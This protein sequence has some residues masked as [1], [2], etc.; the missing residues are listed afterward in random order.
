[1]EVLACLGVSAK[2]FKDGSSKVIWGLICAL[3]MW[4]PVPPGTATT[5]PRFPLPDK[6]W[7]TFRGI[8]SRPNYAGDNGI[9]MGKPGGGCQVE[10]VPFPSVQGNPRQYPGGSFV[11]NTLQCGGLQ[12]DLLL[13]IADG[14][15]WSSHWIWTGTCSGPDTGGFLWKWCPPGIAVPAVDVCCFKSTPRSVAEDGFGGQNCEV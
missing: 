6:W 5:N 13:A 4:G 15:G 7:V 2:D 9:L 1:M 11:V 3:S 12:R 14:G 10:W 8:R